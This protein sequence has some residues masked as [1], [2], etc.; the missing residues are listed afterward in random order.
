MNNFQI[1]K[2]ED[3]Q[4]V[5]ILG[6]TDII[7]DNDNFNTAHILEPADIIVETGDL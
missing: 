5:S 2:L 1:N 7:E 6:G 4:L 3:T